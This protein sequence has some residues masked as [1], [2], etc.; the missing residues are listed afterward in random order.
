MKMDKQEFLSDV[1]DEL[2]A[3]VAILPRAV[4]WSGDD[5]RPGLLLLPGLPMI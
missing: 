2:I 3:S 1:P 5:H 4:L